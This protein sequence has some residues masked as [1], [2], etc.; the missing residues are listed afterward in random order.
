MLETAVT[1]LAETVTNPATGV[2]LSRIAIPA[3]IA[4]AILIVLFIVGRVS[5]KKK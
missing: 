2:E 1:T 4:L 3:G 5:K